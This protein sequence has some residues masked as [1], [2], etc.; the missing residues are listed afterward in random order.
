MNDETRLWLS[1]ADENLEVADLALA[2][3]HF[4][5]CLQNAQQALEMLLKAVIIEKSLEFRRTH[6]IRGLVQVLATEQIDPELSDDDIDLMDTIYLPSKYPVLSA[7]PDAMP[8]SEICRTVMD[9]V[10]NTRA[11]VSRILAEGRQS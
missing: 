10:R 7:L 1:Y 3:G 5:A 4:N 9:I 8:T 2:H 11:S 6:S